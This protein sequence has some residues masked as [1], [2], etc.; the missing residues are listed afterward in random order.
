[1]VPLTALVL[2]IV[3]A[4]VFVFIVSQAAGQKLRMME[5]RFLEHPIGKSVRHNDIKFDKQ[6]IARRGDNAHVEFPA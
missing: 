3:L 4:T 5:H 6:I 1:M 2:P